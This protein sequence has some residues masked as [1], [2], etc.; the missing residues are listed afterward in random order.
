[1]LNNYNEKEYSY[2]IKTI[3]EQDKNTTLVLNSGINVAL[4]GLNDIKYKLEFI[5]KIVKDLDEKN[6]TAKRIKFDKGKNPIVIK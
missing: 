2:K 6:I 5:E 3:I 4:D 1:L